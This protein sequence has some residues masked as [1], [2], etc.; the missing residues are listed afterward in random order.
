MAGW[1]LHGHRSGPAY[2]AQWLP[3]LNLLD[4]DEHA[5]G[6]GRE[7]GSRAAAIQQLAALRRAWC[8]RAHLTGRAARHYERAAQLLTAQCVYTAPVAHPVLV[9]VEEEEGEGAQG[10][11]QGGGAASSSGRDMPAVGAWMYA[12]APVRID[13]AGGWSDT[14]PI[15]YEAHS[16]AAA[17]GGGASPCP[18]PTPGTPLSPA[19]AAAAGGGLVVNAGVLLDGMRCL[20]ARVRRVALSSAAQPLIVVR[21]RGLRSSS[22]P[23]CRGGAS[24]SSEGGAL[25]PSAL[26]AAVQAAAQGHREEFEQMYSSGGAPGEVVLEDCNLHSLGDL[27]D[28]NKPHARG[29]LVKCALLCMR[30]LRLPPPGAQAAGGAAGAA[31]ASTPFPTLQQ[32]LQRLCGSGTGLEVETW[33]LVPMG[34]GLGT[35]SILAGTVLA[36]LAAALG[37][38][39]SRSSLCH[40]VLIVEQ[41]LTTG[42]GWQDQVGGLWPGVKASWCASALPV[43]VRVFPLSPA[44][45]G[46]GHEEATAAL[47]PAAVCDSLDSRLFLLYTGRTRLAKHLLQRVL[48]QWAVRENG[49]TRTVESLRGTAAAMA[50]AL[51]GGDMEAAGAA[52]N[53]YWAQKK[54]MAPLA[55]PPDVSLMLKALEPHI[56]GASLC[57]AGG[58]G[59][60]V[61]IARVA[62]PWPQ[63]KATL[64]AALEACQGLSEEAAAA[65]QLH[66]CTI[67][68]E[69]LAYHRQ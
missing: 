10:E 36:A 8:S 14:P 44:L 35:S 52:L 26:S 59:F 13:L 15:T 24:G 69:G 66:M 37:V 3:A 65:W 60:L 57:G 2:N 62:A 54:D 47:T 28:Y 39:Y 22:S 48:R 5:G 9:G 41:M 58:G 27:A 63:R 53:A 4:G 11:S 20:G 31:A 16:L 40:L 45:Q 17:V 68:K 51:A 67:D 34:S 55:E 49:I 42:G 30:M 1:G 61:G 64:S 56:L 50:G 25:S 12:S 19:A 23:V 29:A 7:P 38:P 43:A 46:L 6:R 18:P 33:S 32:Q 21:T